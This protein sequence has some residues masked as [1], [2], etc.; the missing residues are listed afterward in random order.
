MAWQWKWR[1]PSILI[2]GAESFER[3]EIPVYRSTG[4]PIFKTLL[5]SGCRMDC[6]YC[7]FAYFCKVRRTAWRP[8]KLVRVFLQA[9]REGLVK[10]LFLSSALYGDPE[11]VSSDIIE[12]AERLRRAGYRGYIH[13]R[14]MPGTPSSLIRRALELADRVGINLEAPSPSAF[15]EIAP[16]K[17]SWSLDIYSK[18]LYATRIARDSKRVDTQL[19]LGA[20][21]ESD[22]EV[23]R[24]VETL[25]ARGI[26]IIHFSPYTPVP[27]TPLAE[28][29]RATPL[30]RAHQL[31]EAL[32]LIRDYSFTLRDIEPALT[33]HGFLPPLRTRLKEHI[34][35]LH[36]E[37]FPV[38]PLAASRRELVRV[39]GIGPA[40]A[41]EIIR[42]RSKGRL[43]LELLRKLL[44]PRW[45]KAQRYLDLSSLR[46]A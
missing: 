34:A 4:G 26:G 44:G 6:R 24:L 5:S 23:L 3:I 43:S 33:E 15:Q 29:R 41:N 35:Q 30:W 14:L 45:R 1:E 21:G 39:P 25:V 18:L 31:Y 38:D 17:G 36:P 7:P 10:G 13:L 28:K 46:G 11:R 32:V 40:T 22:E 16:S 20:S 12:V 42:A 37:W 9:Y 19:V 2:R 8:D 27:G